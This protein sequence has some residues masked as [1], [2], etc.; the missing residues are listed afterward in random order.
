MQTPRAVDAAFAVALLVIGALEFAVGDSGTYPA[1]A[2]VM[3]AVGAAAMLVRSRLPLVCLGV[4]VALVVVAQLPVPGVELTGAMVIGCLFALG[5]VGRHCGSATATVALA[6]TAGPVVLS[7]QLGGRMWDAVVWLLSCGTA[8]TAGR[9]MRREAYRAAELAM[10]ARELVT[11]REARAREAVEAERA[12]IA[13]ELH[14]AVAH[15]V[16]VMTVQAA[17]VRRHLDRDP[18]AARQ[19]DA[20]LDV[21][22]LGREAVGELHRAIGLLRGAAPAEQSL[23]APLPRLDDLDRLVAQFRTAGLP[24]EVLVTGTP[25][26]LPPGLD[27]TAYRVVQEALANTMKHAGPARARVTLDYAV[28]G[29]TVHVTDDGRGGAAGDGGHGLVGMRERVA[30]YGGTVEARPADGQGYGVRVVL[31]LPRELGG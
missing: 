15:T 9:L 28:N 29:L 18:A 13:R 8:W 7:S 30:L 26:P 14:D 12:R 24:V 4:F 5:T 17:G 20:L 22:R 2:P 16:S 6:A 23:L 31:P 27:L 11:E 10:L 3:V 1:S 25:R 21:E 19:R